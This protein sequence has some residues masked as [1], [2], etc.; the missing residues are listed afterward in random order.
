MPDNPREFM[1]NGELQMPERGFNNTGR[2]RLM[3]NAFIYMVCFVVIIFLGGCAA[4]PAQPSRD[5]TPESDPIIDDCFS[6]VDQGLYSQAVDICEQAA[7]AYPDNFIVHVSLA[8]ALVSTGQIGRAEEHYIRALEID[9]SVISARMELGILLKDS[10]NYSDALNE[11]RDVINRRPDYV[12]AY[13]EKAQIY[14]IQRQWG[15][16]ADMFGQAVT[17]QPKDESLRADYVQA[18][19]NAGRLSQARSAMNTAASDFPDSVNLAL[20]FGVLLQE[21]QR[22]NEAVAQYNRVLQMDPGNDSAGY[23]IALCYFQNRNI[24]EAERAITRYLHRH[25]KSSSGNVLAAQI[26]TSI[27]NFSEAETYIRRALDIDRNIGAAWVMLG[28]ILRRRNDRRGAAEA[29]REA[30]R[31]NPNDETARRNLRRVY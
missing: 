10:A 21:Q 9:P 5:R 14:R 7:A 1:R 19:V 6:L 30:L 16:A 24:R 4:I 27:N 28:N 8:K 18:L 2:R 26:A 29:Y 3:S 23:N 20:S 25:P 12:L 31:I 22:Y 17:I 11:F 13:M 15:R